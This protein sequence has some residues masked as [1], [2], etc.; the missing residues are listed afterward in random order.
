MKSIACSGIGLALL[1]AVTGV[2]TVAQNQSPSTPASSSSGS[3]LGDYARQIR[4]D[5]GAAKATPIYGKLAAVVPPDA[6]TG[7]YQDTLNVTLT[8]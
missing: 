6:T 2:P 1:L 8:F 3:S 7:A 5:P 4:K